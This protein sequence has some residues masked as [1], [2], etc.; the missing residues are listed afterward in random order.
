MKET[1]TGMFERNINYSKATM[2]WNKANKEERYQVI[3]LASAEEFDPIK[4][5]QFKNIPSDQVAIAD[6]DN[7]KDL[8]ADFPDMKV[9][10]IG[11]FNI[12]RDPKIQTFVD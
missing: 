9:D 8:E 4:F 5:A 1:V 12:F 7:S 2:I 6:I 3:S 10:D 11:L